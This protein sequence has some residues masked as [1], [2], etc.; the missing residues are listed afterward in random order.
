[1][2]QLN[3]PNVAVLQPR[4]AKL[5]QTQSSQTRLQGHLDVLIVGAGLSGIGFA[6][7]LQKHCPRKS[8][9]ILEAR[10]AHR[11]HLGS[12][13]LSRHP[14]RFRHAHARLPLPTLA[15]REVDR[16]R[17]VDPDLSSA[18]PRAEYGIDRKI[19]F[20]HKVKR[21]SWSSAQSALDARRRPGPTVRTHQW[22]C[23]FL[24]MCSGYYDYDGGY[25]PGWPGMDRFKGKILHP[26]KWPDDLDYA[27]PARRRDRQRRHRRDAGAGDDR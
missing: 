26:Q 5:D 1:M 24:Q 12:V 16:R 23:N 20:G 18:R 4:P 14:I 22:T 6:W 25:M 7:H 19:R 11:R 15:W 2:D 13:S 27:A 8:F 10:D 17:P 9:A 3:A 21:A